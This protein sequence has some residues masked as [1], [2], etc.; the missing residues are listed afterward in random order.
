[1][2]TQPIQVQWSLNET[3]QS[4][5]SVARGVLAAA[6]SDNVQPLAILACEKFGGTIAI[7]SRTA[8]KVE[9]IIALSPE[10]APVK[11]L[12]GLVGFF[13]NDCASQLSHT[14]SGIRFLGL[15]A[16]IVT[17]VGPFNGAKA[18]DAMLRDS[19]TDLALL[20][21]V[22]HLNDLL[23]SLEARSYRCGFA[24]SVVGWEIV[25]RREILPSISSEE[26]RQNLSQNSLR[27]PSS[28]TIAC[29]VAAFRQAARIGS[30]TVIGIT[31]KVSKA[32]PWILAFSQWCLEIPPS[33]YVDGI[34]AAVRQEPQSQVK[35]IVTNNS[36]KPLEVIIHHQ[37][38][39][40]TQLLG[41]PSQHF[42]S[43][44]VTI[45][46]YY[47]WLFQQLGFEGDAM[48]RLLRQALEHAIPQVLLGMRSGKFTHL[49]QSTTA[50]NLLGSISNSMDTCYLSPLPDTDTIALT[51]ARALAINGPVTFI[52]LRQG[53]LIADLPLVSRHL[54]SLMEKCLCDQCCESTQR[55]ARPTSN[56]DFCSREGFFRSLGFIIMELFVLSLFESSTPILVRL[57]LERNG[58]HPPLANTVSEVI[59]TGESATFEDIELLDWAR[60]MVGHVFDDEERSLIMTSGKGQVIYPVIFDTLYVEKQG[61]LKLYCLPGALRY[62]NDTYNVVSSPEDTKDDESDN[63]ESDN[64]QTDND[65]TDNDETDDDEIMDDEATYPN[66]PSFP[67]VSKPLNLFKDLILSWKV[68]IR[69]NKEL[70]IKLMMRSKSNTSLVAETDPLFIL[71]SLRDTL[72]LERCPHH[73]SAQLISADRF[74]SYISPWDL[75]EETLGS[76]SHVGVVP[77]DGADDL[78][79]F[80]IVYLDSLILRRGSCLRCCLNLC[81]DTGVPFLVL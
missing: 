10:P 59:K 1:M 28:E 30:S 66:L 67:A 22:R 43:G 61:Y 42:S 64:D 75:V 62:Q 77:V 37:L 4:V 48:F 19:A 55:H 81:R 72:L 35:V 63:D 12:K 31:I 52:N 7:S 26:L 65:Q 5:F 17:T 6:T 73:H 38:E 58:G 71:I 49:G 25:L 54:Q 21:T 40:I 70:H 76:T 78:R 32:A 47:P 27:A 45:D 56:K 11:F 33:L 18:L 16:A 53:M 80:A 14:H 69:E 3:S 20:P 23:E 68:T 29:L 44:M 79:C 57:S 2:S 9:K 39:D 74:A 24:E 46:S 13:P 60:S 34:A 36:S 15:A 8:S 41:P 50:K 51:Y